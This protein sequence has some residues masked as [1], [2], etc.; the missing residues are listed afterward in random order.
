MVSQPM[1]ASAMSL[2]FAGHPRCFSEHSPC[3][4]RVELDLEVVADTGTPNQRRFVRPILDTSRELVPTSDGGSACGQ[5]L[6][7]LTQVGEPFDKKDVEIR[8]L[9]GRFKPQKGV[10][11]LDADRYFTIEQRLKGR[12]LVGLGS[13]MYSTHAASACGS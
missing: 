9:L 7:S 10:L 5:R 1:T 12:P 3:R 2:Q 13:C 11:D 4:R 6:T 8:D